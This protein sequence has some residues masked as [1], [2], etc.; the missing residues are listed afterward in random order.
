MTRLFFIPHDLTF[1]IID[2]ARSPE[3][4]SAA[5]NGNHWKPPKS[6]RDWFAQHGIH[7]TPSG[8]CASVHGNT[9]IV[10]TRGGKNVQFPLAQ[11]AF[12][13]TRRQRQV[14]LALMKGQST[15]EI[16]AS[17]SIQ[18]RTVFSHIA[19]LK[20]SFGSRSRTEIVHLAAAM[21]FLQVKRRSNF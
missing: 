1:L 12:S 9:V 10:T 5:I 17:L 3:D 19:C 13:I 2:S 15:K 20:E 14:L 16:A 21:G 8:L 18:P 7:V 11:P 6:V 4:L